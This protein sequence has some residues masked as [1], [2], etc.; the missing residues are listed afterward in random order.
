MANLGENGSISS[1]RD[2]YGVLGLRKECSTS[3]LRNA[4]KRLALRWH[5]DRCS[6]SGNSKYVEEANSKFQA[7]QQAY[8]VLSDANKRFL[9]DVGA[10]HSDDD[11]DEDGMGDFLNEMADMMSQTEPTVET[12]EESFEQL[13][14][15]F[16]EMFNVDIE[17]SFGASSSLDASSSLSSS[18]T[19]SAASYTS[20][21]QRSNSTHGSS[22]PELK[23]GNNGMKDSLNQASHFQNFSLGTGGKPEGFQ[24]GGGSKRRKNSRRGRR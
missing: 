6:A 19:S 8:S 10:Y 22:S 7:I 24:E 23:V 11:D 16:N 17:S 1:G 14:D 18:S 9:Y 5:P 20:Y 21:F 4:Y 3:D 15:L 2:L 12:G 13:Q